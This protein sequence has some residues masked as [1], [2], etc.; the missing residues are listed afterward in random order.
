[1]TS[2]PTE[3][4]PPSNPLHKLGHALKPSTIASKLHRNKDDTT[5]DDNLEQGKAAQRTEEKRKEKEEKAHRAEQEKKE[6]ERRRKESDVIAAK[7]EDKEM[8]ERYGDLEIPGEIILIDDVV[9]LPEGRNVTFRA[10]I[11]TQRELSSQ[12][13]FIIFRH[14]GFTLQ[15]VLSGK[16]ASEHMIKWTERI[17]DESIVQVSGT[18][19]KPPNP[20]KFSTDSPLELRIETL[21]L[22]EPS[23][24]IPFGLYH[25]NEPPPQRSRLNNRTLDLRHPTNQAIFKIR[26]RLLRVF[27]DTLDELD[28]IEINTPKLQ[29]AATESGAE[30]FRVNYFGRKA[31]LAQSPQLMKQMAISADFGR[32]YEIGPVFRAENSNTHR[33]LTEYT[34]LDIELSLKQD[35]HEVFHVLDAILKNMFRALSTM[36][37]ELARVREVWD[38]EEFVFLE[39]TPIIPFSEAIQMLR[40]D[41]RDVEEEDLHT[42]DEI[43]LGQLVKQKYGTDYYIVDRFPK[44]ARPFYTAND[45]KTTNSFDM[46]IRGQEICT[47]G[48]RIHDSFKLR[49]SMR[50]SGIEETEMEEYLSAFDWGMPPHGGAGLGL[51]RIITFYLDLPDIRLS[52][53]FHRDPHSLPA[54]K[55]SLPHP[56]ADTTKPRDSEH[57]LPPLEDMIANYGDATN[58]S[59]LDDR[60]DIWRDESTGAAV[61]YVEQG[62]FCMITGDPLCADQQK[63]EITK[64]F[65]VFVKDQLKLKPVWMLV[66]SEFQEV[67]SEKYGWRSL[68]CTQEQR[69][70]SDKVSSEV[71][72]NNKLQ[73][74]V[75]KVREIDLD[76]D[77][78]R[79]KDAIDERIR[80]W[81]DHRAGGGKK[82]KQIH[83]TEIAPW[84][85]S[86]HRRYFIAE[87]DPGKRNTSN[88]HSDGPALNGDGDGESRVE[89]LV[90]LTRLSPKHGYQL[91]W[92]LDF[93][94]SPKGA[95]EST[96]QSALSAVPGEP[97]TFGASVSE[98]FVTSNGI[99]EVRSKIME[100]TY[101]GI[102]SSLSLD[103]KAEFREKFGVEGERTWICYPKNGV[104]VTELGE[105]VKFFEE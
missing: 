91:K 49:E 105:I 104:R 34:G 70:N 101:K 36:K 40:D 59:W 29:P 64:K 52:S 12:L 83:L 89:T 66:S 37:N 45:G 73:K 27:R 13:D 32:V 48:Q 18:L 85:D 43:R 97:V 2:D 92:A 16:I 42:P 54:K 55:P 41:G 44:S 72:Q 47:G 77:G 74:G 9:Q 51:E 33:H 100:R 62:K 53:L 61:G 21:H 28:F 87:S 94:S 71:I 60:F 78:G 7:T 1:M 57:E 23:K 90:V 103:K 46:F 38:S 82:G 26:A 50:E 65:L 69:S 68:S 3:S 30:V 11:H 76:E 5:E 20:I 56:E 24:N 22:V 6:V 96:V 14:R 25:G 31:F 99:G 4:V 98:S 79:L 93:P 86:G 19:A 58:T 95:I 81:Q 75:F 39:E 102:V 88:G 63:S 17:P 8:R 15:G 84:R 10:R 67:L 80:E 35:Y